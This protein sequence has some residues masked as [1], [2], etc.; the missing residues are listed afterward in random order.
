MSKITWILVANSSYARIL[1]NDGPKKGLKLV[2]ELE[3]P[4]SREKR[5]DLVSDRP[6]HNTGGTGSGRGAFIPQTDPSK[7]EAENFA[8]EVAK[9]LE[10]GRVTQGYER[11]IL[12]ASNPFIGLLNNRIGGHVRAMVSD[13]I[14]KDYTKATEKELARHLEHCIFL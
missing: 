2:K 13:T 3:H 9:E 8:L 5:L 4:Q 14:E 10:H 11:L 6:G 1:G 7:H 12:V